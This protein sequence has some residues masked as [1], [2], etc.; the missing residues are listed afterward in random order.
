MKKKVVKLCTSEWEYESRDKR[1]LSVLEELNAEV[2]VIAKGEITGKVDMV[3]G[4][5][6]TR[7]S[8][9]PLGNAIP[10]SL[11]RCISIFTWACFVRRMEADIISGHDITALLIGYLSN[12]LKTA[13][14]K[15]KLVYDSH[16]FEIGRCIDRNR[17]TSFFII[18]LERFL[19][20][21]CAFSIM[22]NDSIADEVQKI[23]KLK[24]RSIVVRSTPNYWNID[25]NEV[26]RVR[27]DILLKLNISD[28]TFILMYHGMIVP[29]RG[30]ENLIKAMARME[31][32]AAIILG[33]GNK[34]YLKKIQGL[35]K[36]LSVSQKIFFHDAVPIDEL[37]KFIGASNVG[38][39][40][41]RGTYKSYFYMLPNKFFENIQGL[42]PIIVSNFPEVRKLTE[43]Y[44]IGLT[45]NPE[46]V[47]EIAEAI[48]KMQRD[49][50]FYKQCKENL[51][52]AKKELCWE[53]EKQ[54]LKKAYIRV[55]KQ[56]YHNG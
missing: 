3:G 9:R 42:T 13:G 43:K 2:F 39:V 6:V 40:I 20:K 22:V 14:K 50:E 49:K 37:Y 53:K 52:I 45:V 30:I 29:D 26:N 34:E 19:I 8:T 27:R 36:E 41:G 12:I 21:K 38:M 48:R 15:A 25:D 23:H 24:N 4:Y 31:N 1:E 18:H 51:K 5:Q 10:D 17:L 11:N 47:D 35:A 33:N 54:V 32:T 28:N 56:K 7:I 55:L 16:E 46:S 44:G